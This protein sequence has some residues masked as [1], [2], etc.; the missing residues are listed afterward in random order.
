M[1]QVFLPLMPTVH[2][3]GNPVPQ[4]ITVND[5]EHRSILLM[6]TVHMSGNPVPQSIT[7]NDDEHR[8]ILL[9]PTTRAGQSS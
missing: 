9:M 5:D 6:P 7:V 4:S 1:E 8:S 2:M 3:S